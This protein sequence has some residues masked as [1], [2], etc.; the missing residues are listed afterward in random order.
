[1]SEIRNAAGNGEANAD[2]VNPTTERVAALAHET[3][4]RVA[5]T[6]NAAEQG[7][8]SA[9]VRTAEAAKRGQ[10]QAVEAAGEDLRHV[11]AYIERNPLTT[12]G[13]AFA[14]GV[15]LSTLIRR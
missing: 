2:Q 8:R 1:M 7:V 6:V 10:G 4:D 15:L 14:V 11:R 3:I 9:A 12:A 5:K 13:I